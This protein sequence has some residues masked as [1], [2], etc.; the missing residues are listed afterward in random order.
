MLIKSILMIYILVCKLE[1]K[2]VPTEILPVGC[3]TNS[4]NKASM[5]TCGD[6]VQTFI[7][8]SYSDGNKL[9]YKVPANG[10][11]LIRYYGDCS[12]Y[13]QRSSDTHDFPSASDYIMLIGITTVSAFCANPSPNLT[14]GCTTFKV[15]DG[16]S[17]ED[18]NE[19][20]ICVSINYHDKRKLL[21]IPDIMSNMTYTRRHLLTPPAP[22]GSVPARNGPMDQNYYDQEHNVLVHRITNQNTYLYMLV[23]EVAFDGAT[24]AGNEF[25]ADNTNRLAQ[26]MN[27]AVNTQPATSRTIAVTLPRIGQQPVNAFLALTGDNYLRDLNNGAITQIINNAANMATI[28]RTGG[29]QGAYYTIA[30]IG[31]YSWLDTE[32]VVRIGNVMFQ[33]FNI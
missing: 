31:I 32:T 27:S 21:G 28:P 10:H 2:K 18:N 20:N 30:C 15:T 12:V 26:R 24:G 19:Y 11:K 17:G 33:L 14:R 3:D 22:P 25:T 5:H 29:N 23:R 8:A 9:K 7:P 4:N 16:F 1:A 13:L 6:L